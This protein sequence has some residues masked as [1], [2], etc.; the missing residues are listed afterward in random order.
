VAFPECLDFLMKNIN[1]I[2]I[3]PIPKTPPTAIPT[4]APMDNVDDDDGGEDGVGV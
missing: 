4:I 2:T 1:K 3:T